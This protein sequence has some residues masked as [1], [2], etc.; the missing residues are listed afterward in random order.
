DDHL[1]NHGFLHERGGWA[2]SPV[3]DVN[4]N[5][6]TDTPRR[7]TIGGASRREDALAALHAYA[8]DFDLDDKAAARVLSEVRAAV[9]GWRDIAAANSVP[10][11][12]MEMFGDAFWT[13]NKP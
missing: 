3:F 9:S 1:R 2:L 4:P 10:E 12:Q 8:G 11:K 13:P 7:T 6:D 5:P